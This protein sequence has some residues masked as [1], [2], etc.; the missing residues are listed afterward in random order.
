M[1]V[2]IYV[3]VSYRGFLCYHLYL[4]SKGTTTNETY[5]WSMCCHA[6]IVI[7]VVLLCMY[8]ISIVI[9]IYMII[10]RVYCIH[11]SIS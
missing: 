11:S 5:K 8:S 1:F 9:S 2:F 7:I 4:I 10:S 3:Y 6:C